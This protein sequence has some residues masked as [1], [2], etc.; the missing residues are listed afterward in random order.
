MDETVGETQVET[1]METQ[2][3][4]QEEVAGDETMAESGEAE[5]VAGEQVETEAETEEANTAGDGE[6]G[7]GAEGS[8]DEAAEVEE[9]AGPAEGGEDGAQVSAEG[10]ADAVSSEPAAPEERKKIKRA[11]SSYFWFIG[12]RR[13]AVKE[14]NPGLGLGPMQKLLA[15]EW[16]NLSD[17]DKLKYETLAREDKER[18]QTE[19]AEQIER[20]GPEEKA[21]KGAPIGRGELCFPLARVK[22]LIKQDPDVKN[23]AAAGAKL[24]A[25]ATELFIAMLAEDAAA[26]AAANKRRYSG[27]LL[28]QHTAVHLLHGRLL[29]YL[30]LQLGQDGEGRGFQRGRVPTRLLRLAAGGL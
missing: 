27:V 14:A 7:E 12:E 29:I 9:E 3:E 6:I 4:T 13:G 19:L 25:K 20:L 17:E 18:Y 22:K 26:A 16:K 10:S 11:K 8:M 28:V 23:I 21:G 5:A 15:E 30:E 1:Q 2:M 24:I